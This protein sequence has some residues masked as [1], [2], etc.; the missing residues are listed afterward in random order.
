ML[1]CLNSE[2]QGCESPELERGA[3]DVAR[4]L[5]GDT[6]HLDLGPAE[7]DLLGARDGVFALDCV[8]ARFRLALHELELAAPARVF[9]VA[10]T[11]GA[12]AAPVAY[13]AGR[14]D[15]LGAVWFDAHGDLNTPASSPSGHFHGMVLRTLLGDGP[16]EFTDHIAHPLDPGR[17]LVAGARDLDD[18]ERDYIESAGIGL[19]EGWPDDAARRV[20]EALRSAG[21]T[22]LYVH[23]DVDVFDPAA[24]GDALFSVPDGPSMGSVAAAVHAVVDSFDV[25]G[26]GVVES[27]GREPGAVQTLA[28]FLIDSGLW[29]A[30]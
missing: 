27:C 7:C 5:F 6:P 1:L 18:A 23:V 12:E 24:Y 22:Q 21:V 30:D 17:V 9:T 16:H 19:V 10:G 20:V 4:E 26:V 3:R 28:S 13:M 11:C 25:V 15:G 29:P 14:Y 8:A 2:W